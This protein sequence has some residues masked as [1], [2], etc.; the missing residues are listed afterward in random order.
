MAKAVGVWLTTKDNPYDPVDQYD[1]WK[2]FDKMH[3]HDC[4]E[5][6]ARFAHTSDQ[7]TDTEN[8]IEIENAIKEIISVD[9][10]NEYTMVKK[11]FD[12]IE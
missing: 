3:H 9:P 8:T 1:E 4:E 10:F 12:L 11:E 6:L 2:L 7:L 5:V